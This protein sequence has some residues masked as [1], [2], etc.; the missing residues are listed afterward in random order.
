M[1]YLDT[2]VEGNG[3]C[4][5]AAGWYNSVTPQGSGCRVGLTNVAKEVISSG[6]FPPECQP[7]Y[8]KTSYWKHVMESVLSSTR[9]VKSASYSPSGCVGP[10][11]SW[12]VGGGTGGVG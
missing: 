9:A 8:P 2:H 6:V 7:V 12:E 1:R 11:M 4:L 5:R 3:I 10:D